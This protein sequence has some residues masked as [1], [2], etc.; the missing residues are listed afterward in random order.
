MEFSN[1][2]EGSS[3]WVGLVQTGAK[4]FI[5]QGQGELQSIKGL[6][7]GENGACEISCSVI[8]NFL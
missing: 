1:L 5:S 8:S 7:D 2:A 6:M 4:S 3:F